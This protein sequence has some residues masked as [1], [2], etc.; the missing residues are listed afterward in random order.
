M[1]KFKGTNTVSFSLD[2]EEFTKRPTD[3]EASGINNRI[4]TGKIVVSIDELAHYAKLIGEKGR[5]FSLATFTDGKRRQKNFEQMQILALDFD[6]GMSLDDAMAQA[7]LYD[8]KPFAVY[9]TFRSVNNDRFRFMF[10][11]STS[12]NNKKDAEVHL[13]MLASIFPGI[14]ESCSKD[15]S[16]MYFGGK[17]L[18]FVD[19]EIPMVSTESLARNM[20]S[21]FRQRYGETNYKKRI[22]GS[23]KEGCEGRYPHRINT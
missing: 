18:L 20:T 6:G 5:S 13:D 16:K 22:L 10:L 15:V 11:N 14:D 21:Y 12:I 19:D 8:M 7:E 4:A 3:D 2:S 9:E 1:K 17:K 23:I